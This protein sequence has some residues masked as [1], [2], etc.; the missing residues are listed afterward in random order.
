MLVV[1]LY[2]FAMP[3]SKGF[4]AGKNAVDTFFAEKLP[5]VASILKVKGN[6]HDVP[7]FK[8]ES[9]YLTEDAEAYVKE[10]VWPRGYSASVVRLSG[11]QY[12][13]V[14]GMN[15]QAARSCSGGHL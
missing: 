11:K 4:F 2:L 15:R 7:V 1:L 9:V 10:T 12:I 13:C 8:P 3:L 6:G 5:K 14:E